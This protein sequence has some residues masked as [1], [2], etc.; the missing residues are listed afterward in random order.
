MYNIYIILSIDNTITAGINYEELY[1]CKWDPMRLTNNTLYRWA[2]SRYT[3][4]YIL[5]S[6][7][8]L[9]AHFLYTSI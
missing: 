1:D 3:L 2:K 6:V 9:L 7:Y 8:L 4:Y 5:Q